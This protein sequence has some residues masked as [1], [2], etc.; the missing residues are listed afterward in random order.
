VSMVL[1]SRRS[2]MPTLA[3]AGVRCTPDR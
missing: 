2:L 3:A 1:A